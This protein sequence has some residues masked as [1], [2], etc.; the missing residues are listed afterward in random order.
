MIKSAKRIENV[1]GKAN[2]LFGFDDIMEQEHESSQHSSTYQRQNDDDF[3]DFLSKGNEPAPSP[4]NKKNEAN[5]FFD[6]DKMAGESGSKSSPKK[7]NPFDDFEW[8]MSFQK[9]VINLI[10]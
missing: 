3:G 8:E 5:D 4:V 1:K 6:F 2:D 7:F 9:R 10:N